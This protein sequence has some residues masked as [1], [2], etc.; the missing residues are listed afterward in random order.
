MIKLITE[1]IKDEILEPAMRAN[2]QLEIWNKIEAFLEKIGL[3]MWSATIISGILALIIVFAI[4]SIPGA[5]IA[6][7]INKIKDF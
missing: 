3:P 4:I 6:W 2:Q 7:I 1:Y 5:I